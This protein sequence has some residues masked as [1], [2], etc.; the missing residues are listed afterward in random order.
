LEYE[1]KV[2]VDELADKVDLR[3]LIL[4][5]VIGFCIGLASGFVENPPEASVI[6]HKYYGWPLA[7][8]IMRMFLGEAY[9]YF[10]LFVDCLFWF[11]IVAIVYVVVKKLVKG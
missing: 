6:G 2:K 10:E 3:G 11:L 1:A 5:V 8:R 4:V 7:W 9:L